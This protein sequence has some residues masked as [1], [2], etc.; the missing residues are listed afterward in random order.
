MKYIVGQMKQYPWYPSHLPDEYIQRINE[1]GSSTSI[2]ADPMNVDYLEYVAW[3]FEGNTPEEY[4]PP[5]VS[6]AE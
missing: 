6:E 2:P 1:D 5:T 3:L 4:V